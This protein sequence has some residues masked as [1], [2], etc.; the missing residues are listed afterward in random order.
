MAIEKVDVLAFGAHADDVEIGMAGAIAKWAEEG[1]K[2]V[3]CD[4]TEAELSSNGN[5]ES[6]KAEAVKAAASIGVKERIN[7]GIPDR[8]LF[9]TQEHIRMVAD[10]I[11]AYRA[12]S[13]FAP[14]YED[15]HPDH[16]NCAAIVKEAFFSAGIRKFHTGSDSPS[17]KAGFLYYYCI[18]SEPR[19]DFV[20]DISDY[21]PR[22]LDA[23]GAYQSQFNPGAGGVQTPLTSGY[24]ERVEARERTFGFSAGVRY[25]EGFKS[26]RPPL[27][28]HNLF[29][30][31]L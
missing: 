10:V 18:N 2:V 26:E 16:A 21:M 27:I 8:G 15:R 6:R 4:L 14:F 1:R 19:P 22:K 13:V 5:V 29:G 24:L 30:E 20:V 3:I 12:V 17:H 25:A 9:L 23:L 7:L 11:R 31:G 28:N